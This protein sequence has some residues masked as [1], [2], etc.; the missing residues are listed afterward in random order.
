[1]ERSGAPEKESQRGEGTV[2]RTIGEGEPENL[3]EPEMESLA[4]H[5]FSLP[6]VSC[7]I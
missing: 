2:C 3:K 4:E 6:V 5:T 7:E 1:M